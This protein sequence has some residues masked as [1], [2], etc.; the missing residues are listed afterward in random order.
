MAGTGNEDGDKCT[1]TMYDGIKGKLE[2]A[3]TE[4]IVAGQSI[5]HYNESRDT[6]SI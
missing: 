1:A 4:C 2:I 3:E 6:R 5:T